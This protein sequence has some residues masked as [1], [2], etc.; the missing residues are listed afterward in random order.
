MV[1]EFRTLFTNKCID[2]AA[3]VMPLAREF[4]QVCQVFEDNVN[5]RYGYGLEL[6]VLTP[7]D[8]EI[9]ARQFRVPVAL[10]WVSLNT[11]HLQPAMDDNQGAISQLAGLFPPQQAQFQPQAGFFLTKQK[12]LAD[13]YA[14][15]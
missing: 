10:V 1:T 14:D 12:Q 8:V 15:R 6:Q 5:Q 11:S 2:L 7:E 3:T 13:N 9:W 4:N